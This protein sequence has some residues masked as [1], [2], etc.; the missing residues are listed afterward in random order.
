MATSLEVRLPFLDH[1]LVEFVE[2]IPS[3]LKLKDLTGKYIHK[4]AMEKWLPREIVYRK[5]KGFVNPVD[6]WL[7]DKMVFFVNDLLLGKK[8]A[9]QE[10][11]HSDYI[12]LMLQKHNER[13]EDFQRQIFLLI[14]FEMWYQQFINNNC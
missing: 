8:F 12:K 10:Y 7:R 1:E 9:C 13:K 5:K 3:N 6:E 4:K 11:F 14:S 2:T